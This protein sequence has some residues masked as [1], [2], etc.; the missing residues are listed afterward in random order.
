VIDEIARRTTAS[1]REMIAALVGEWNGTYRLWLEPGKLRTQSSTRCTG[2][3]VLEGRFVA[4]D[5]S[6]T[7]DDGP[8]R[9]SMLLGRTDEGTWE[10]AWID[11]WHTGTS[12]LFCVG[13]PDADMLGSYGPSDEPWGWRTR[14]DLAS[15]DEFTITAW[16]ITPAGDEVKATEATYRR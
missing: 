8:Q 10:M 12:M 4:V 13:G 1:G 6:W 3:S 2:R 14:F 7:D 5:Y 11:T 16:N 9:G 15:S